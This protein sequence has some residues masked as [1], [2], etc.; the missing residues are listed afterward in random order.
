MNRDQYDESRQRKEQSK[1]KQAGRPVTK[2]FIIIGINWK[3]TKQDWQKVRC[4]DK[5]DEN[6]SLE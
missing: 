2:N 1:S 4:E 5:K 3:E 6:M